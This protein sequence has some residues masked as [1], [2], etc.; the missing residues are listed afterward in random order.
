MPDGGICAAPANQADHVV[1]GDDH[2][3]SN[4]QSLCAPHHA[5]KSGREGWAERHR[6]IQANSRRFRRTEP[7]PGEIAP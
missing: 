1:R 2:R 6:L 7:H 4:L 5:S 3:L